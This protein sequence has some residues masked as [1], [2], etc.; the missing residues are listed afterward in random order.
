[1]EFRPRPAELEPG[2][3][4]FKEWE[5]V[6][7]VEIEKLLS[8]LLQLDHQQ[9]RIEGQLHSVDGVY[10]FHGKFDPPDAVRTGG[11]DPDG[12][13]FTLTATGIMITNS[14]PQYVGLGFDVL[15]DESTESP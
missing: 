8:E 5:F 10:I 3:D 2:D 12:E 11:V 14:D 15:K 4:G 1:L 9:F 6:P 13:A 7:T